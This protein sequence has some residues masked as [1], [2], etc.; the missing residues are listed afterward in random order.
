MKPYRASELECQRVIVAAAKRGGWRCHAQ[1][2][3]LQRSGK[4]STAIM[5]DAGF[6][7]LVLSHPT[8]GTHMIELK[9]APNKVEPAQQQWLNLLPNARVVWV[10]EQLD[11]CVNWLVN[12]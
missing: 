9:R 11:E 2:A 12:G 7:D 4:W 10:P 1:R 5:G 6:P 3:A 8:R